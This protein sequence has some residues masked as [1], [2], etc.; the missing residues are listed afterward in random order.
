[1]ICQGEP[2]PGADVRL[3][4]CVCAHAR[5]R[6]VGPEAD[7]LGDS[8]R[9]MTILE[10][11]SARTAPC[12]AGGVSRAA[13][14][15]YSFSPRHKPPEPL[16]VHKYRAGLGVPLA[17]S[18]R[19]Q[20]AQAA[21]ASAMAHGAWRT[22]RV[23]CTHMGRT[24]GGYIPAHRGQAAAGS[25][26]CRSHPPSRARRSTPTHEPAAPISRV[27]IGQCQC[28]RGRGEPSSGADAAEGETSGGA[29]VGGS[30]DGRVFTFAA[31]PAIRFSS[32]SLASS[33]LA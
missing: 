14:L 30:D 4:A 20:R 13:L 3:R 33:H 18:A 10:L 8:S 22:A 25:R 31:M 19:A 28:R 6:F 12:A 27:G 5:V 2:S 11:S 23:F 7:I 32:R 9:R 15:Q 17:G 24:A 29:E 1:M 16:F 21:R 26:A